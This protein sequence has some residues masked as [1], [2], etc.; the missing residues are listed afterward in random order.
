VRAGLERYQAACAR[1]F[2]AYLDTRREYYSRERRWPDAPF[3]RR[4]Q[5]PVPLDLQELLRARGDG[6][7]ARSSI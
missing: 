5:E 4:R 3:W 7:T 6:A 2:E 1:E